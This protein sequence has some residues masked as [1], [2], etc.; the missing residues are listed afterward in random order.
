MKAR[1]EQFRQQKQKESSSYLLPEENIS[2]GEFRDGGGK[3]I[4]ICLQ[5]KLYLFGNK[6]TF[7]Q[8]DS[9]G[10]LLT[11]PCKDFARARRKSQPL[12]C[13]VVENNFM[14]V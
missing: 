3:Y 1:I 6:I 8:Q 11:C 13:L 10:P 4:H 5:R 9:L 12:Q 7:V 2:L 14:F